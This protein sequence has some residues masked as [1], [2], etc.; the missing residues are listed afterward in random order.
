[1]QSSLDICLKNDPMDVQQNTL[2]S[3]QNFLIQIGIFVLEH[4][5]NPKES[6]K[7]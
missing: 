1:M 2:L 4:V 3:V 5:V 7:I 6:S